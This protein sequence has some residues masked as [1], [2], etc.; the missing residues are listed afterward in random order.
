MASY[1]AIAAGS[2]VQ[3]RAAQAW[4]DTDLAREIL[5][6]GLRALD[7]CARFRSPC[8]RPLPI[9]GI[10]SGMPDPSSHA[11]C[12]LP[13]SGFLPAR[14][15]G[16]TAPG[17]RWRGHRS[18]PPAQLLRGV[19]LSRLGAPAWLLWG[20]T[21]GGSQRTGA[22]GD[23]AQPARRSRV[24]SHRRRGRARAVRAAARR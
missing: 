6:L 2:D 3:A 1:V 4:P 21:A 24:F 20:S 14:V 9:Q 23:A 15:W 16:V 22:A 12:C 17:H 11:C 19:L 10:I 7:T 13:G 8:S 18:A 5:F